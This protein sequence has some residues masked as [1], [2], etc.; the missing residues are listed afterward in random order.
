ML[1]VANTVAV[2]AMV[3]LFSQRHFVVRQLYFKPY[4]GMF[5]IKTSNPHCTYVDCGEHSACQ[6]KCLTN[7]M[8]CFVTSRYTHYQDNNLLFTE[9]DCSTEA[10]FIYLSEAMISHSTVYLSL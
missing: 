7:A 9:D 2:P 10:R 4:N 6:I 3:C 1:I 8:V 5:I